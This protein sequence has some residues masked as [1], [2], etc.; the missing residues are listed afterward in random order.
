MLNL[1]V[2]TIIA[3]LLGSISGS[4]VLGKFRGVDIRTSGSGNAGGTNALRTMGLGFAL[5]VVLI[6]VG[7][8][9]LAV[10]WAAHLHLLG[11]DALLQYSIYSCGFAAILGHMYPVFFAFRGGKGA[12]TYLGTLISISPLGLLAVLGCWLVVALATGFVGLSTVVA[13][14]SGAVLIPLLEGAGTNLIVYLVACAAIIAFAHR[15]NFKRMAAGNENRFE[16]LMIK[17]W[18]RK[19]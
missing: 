2:N 7:K 5:G 12:G 6:D 17:N 3:Y 18:R 1:I 4:L 11:S 14:A 9:W 8:G 13:V 10:V 16:K 19:P 15:E